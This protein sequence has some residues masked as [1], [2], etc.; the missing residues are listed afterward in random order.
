[1]TPISEIAH[2]IINSVL[3]DFQASLKAIVTY[4]Y[5]NTQ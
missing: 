2:P 5:L 1:M 3:G 4:A